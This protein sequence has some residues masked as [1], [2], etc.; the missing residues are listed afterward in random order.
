MFTYIRK[1]VKTIK[2]FFNTETYFSFILL[3]FFN[4][5]IITLFFVILTKLIYFSFLLKGLGFFL[6]HLYR[7]EE[8]EKRKKK[9]WKKKKDWLL[10][11]LEVSLCIMIGALEVVVYEE[12]G[13][14][15]L[16]Q[17]YVFDWVNNNIQLTEN[18]KESYQLYK[19][20]DD[21]SYMIKGTIYV[22]CTEKFY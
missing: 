6:N 20:Y 4:L 11:F 5:V 15:I 9:E 3:V 16:P 10:L 19:T 17:M 18:A 1:L 12:Y 22:D 8:E 13:I 7:Y 21:I 14:H 2:N